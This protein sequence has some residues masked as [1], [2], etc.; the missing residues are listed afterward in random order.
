MQ[1]KIED[2]KSEE[3]ELARVFEV[4]ELEE[5]IEFAHWYKHADGDVPC[6]DDPI[7]E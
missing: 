5:R 3:L 1:S 6:P 4:E 2:Q 7:Q